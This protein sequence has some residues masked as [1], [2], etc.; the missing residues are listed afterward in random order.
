MTVTDSSAARVLI[1]EDDR[2]LANLYAEWLGQHYDIETAHNGTDALDRLDETTEV[3]MLDRMMAGLSGDDA[4][5]SI[6]QTEVDPQIVIISAVTPD[7][8]TVQMGFDRYLQKPID[9]QTIHETIT[10]MLTRAEYDEQLRELFSLI[11][12]KTTLEAVKQ[13]ALLKSSDEYQSLIERL[14]TVQTAVE[15]LLVE[16]PDE[17]YQVAVEHL[18]RSPTE[19]TSD[20]QQESLT[21][22]VLGNSKDATVV[23]DED[24]LVVWANQ[25][26]ERLLRVDPQEIRGRNYATVAAEQFRDVD[27]ETGSLVSLIQAGVTDE[28]TEIET[29]V[30]VPAGHDRTERWLEYWSAPI[31]TGLHAGGRIEH[32]HDVTDRH[33]R[34]QRLQRLHTVTRDLMAAETTETVADLATTAARTDLGVSLAALYRQDRETGDLVPI[35]HETAPGGGP[36]PSAVSPGSDPIWTAF[37]DRPDRL[38]ADTYRDRNGSSGWLTDRFTDWIVYPLDQQEVFVVATADETLSPTRRT[39]TETLAASTQQALEQIARTQ[40]YRDRNQRLDRE[41]KR[42]SRLD[43]INQ[44]IR[45][46]NSAIVSADSREDIQRVVC[47]RLL[48]ID[49]LTGAWIADVDPVTDDLVCRASAGDLGDYLSEVPQAT[50]ETDTAGT[51][52][53]TPAVPARQAYDTRSS[54]S[55]ADLVT[56]DSGVWWRDSGLTRGSDVII[57]VPLVHESTRFGALEVHIDRPGG[58]Q[59]AAVEAL[60]ELGVITGH[61][62]NALQRRDT[63]SAGGGVH[64][65]FQVDTESTLCRFAS[66]TDV[67]LDVIDISQHADNTCSVFMRADVSAAD[68]EQVVS[69][70]DANPGVSLLRDGASQLTCVVTLSGNSAVRRLISRGAALQEVEANPDPETLDVTVQ[71]PPE[72]DV[73][74][75]VDDVTDS[76]DDIEV[77]AKQAL[78]ADQLPE[79]ATLESVTDQLTDRQHETLRTAFHAGYFNWPRSANAETVASEIGIAQSTLSQHLRTAERKLLEKLFT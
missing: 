75:Y 32:Y 55:V 53:A 14:N 13:P 39:L 25:A 9:A 8:D 44:L 7:F 46:L 12:Q 58:V 23:T 65:Q 71:V 11:E 61:G 36:E 66:Q 10:R 1:V 60:A 5:A 41:A 79:S 34:E 68:R 27:T 38:D 31:D 67:P 72:T 69:Q 20:L 70:I 59:D 73:R 74:S 43:Q 24:G 49:H 33:Q 4:L 28:E 77:V 22:D 2:E 78:L 35:A 42:L 3:V 18:Q 6:Q 37:T 30:H 52:E 19:Q 63:L 21:Q 50:S 40:K 45:S 26:T 64:L 17:E 57:A 54:V 15:S 62:I 51:A 16:L 76:I 47:R 56:V 48:Q 29:T